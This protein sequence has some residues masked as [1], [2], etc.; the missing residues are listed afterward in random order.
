MAN[1]LLARAAARRREIAVRTALGAERGRLVRQLLTESVVLA[2]LGGLAGL[3]VAQWLVTGIVALAPTNVPRLSEVSLNPT[4]LLFAL[5]VSIGTGILFGL[6]PAL[7]ASRTDLSAAFRGAGAAAMGGRET[8]RLRSSLIVAEVALSVVLLVGAGLML[9]SFA[10]LSAVNPGFDPDQLLTM[11]VNLPPSSYPT[12]PEVEDS[13]RRAIEAVAALPGVRSI[14]GISH[15]PLTGSDWAILL[16]IDGQPAAPGADP[17]VADNRL[18]TPGYFATMGIPVKGRDITP[19]DRV[20]AP[21]VILINEAMAQRFWPGQSALG[22]RVKWGPEN[23]PRPW[24]TVVGIAGN[25]NHAALDAAPI[26]EVYM[27]LDQVPD[28]VA[29]NFRSVTLVVRTNGDPERMTAAVRSAIRSVAR[30]APISLIATM[31]QVR[32]TSVSPRRFTLLLLGSFAVLALVLSAVGIYGVVMYGVTQRTRDIGVRV[33][34][35]ARPAQ[36][37][38][39]ILGQ[40]LRLAVFGLG[41]GVVGAVALTRVLRAQLFDVSPTDPATFAAIV[42]LLAAVAAL[43]SWLPARRAT[44]VDPIEALRTE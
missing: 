31:D 14:G 26:P 2:V 44:R 1:L 29:A 33:A 39:A 36:V 9:R 24:A 25:I 32:A 17:N 6:T 43:A 18:I 23:S 16:S 12:R 13:R 19:A 42:V 27:P 21:P 7:F 15:L 20:D 38:G 30:N 40:G 35:G 11:R 41:I 10:K 37:V 8:T 4:I 22:Q 3:G 5:V 34:L 28:E